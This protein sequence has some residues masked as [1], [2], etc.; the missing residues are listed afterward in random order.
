MIAAHNL[1]YNRPLPMLIN[2]SHPAYNRRSPCPLT[3]S[4]PHPSPLLWEV[5]HNL[6]QQ[7]NNMMAAMSPTPASWGKQTYTQ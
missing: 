3:N 6:Q 2:I 4:L 5:I 7:L 1:S